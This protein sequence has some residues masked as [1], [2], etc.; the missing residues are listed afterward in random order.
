M[1]RICP[2]ARLFISDLAHAKH[3]LTKEKRVKY[4]KTRPVSRIPRLY[5]AVFAGLSAETKWGS[6]AAGSPV[7]PPPTC[8][9]DCSVNSPGAYQL[10]PQIPRSTPR[11]TGFRSHLSRILLVHYIISKPSGI[12]MPV[13]PS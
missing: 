2:G 9:V 8:S 10:P 7:R 12:R 1:P 13:A 3:I 6:H 4:R 5:L 11:S